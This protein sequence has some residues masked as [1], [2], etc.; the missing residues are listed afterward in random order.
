MHHSTD[1]HKKT[2]DGRGLK[3]PKLLVR[4]M[5]GMASKEDRER[6]SPSR[7][8]TIGKMMVTRICMR[9]RGAAPADAADMV[10]AGWWMEWEA[11]GGGPV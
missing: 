9:S 4:S 5:V 11:D 1:V 3:P 10:V 8:P 7:P 6:A 2:Q